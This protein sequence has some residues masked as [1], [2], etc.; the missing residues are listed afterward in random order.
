MRTALNRRQ[1]LITL[2]AAALG[3]GSANAA[4]AAARQARHASWVF[5]VH[6]PVARE[7][8]PVPVEQR[9]LRVVHGRVVRMGSRF[10]K[11]LPS[12]L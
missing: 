11:H 8:A 12:P 6:D 2:C 7:G 5:L 1:G 10:R 3:A 4:K 9:E